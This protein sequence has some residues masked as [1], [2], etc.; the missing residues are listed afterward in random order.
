MK[1]ININI[2]QVV[3]IGG[4]FAI[5]LVIL[6]LVVQY[7]VKWEDRD[8]DSYLFFYNCNNN[9]CTTNNKID[10]YY[11]YIKCNGTECPYI[12]EIKDNLVILST[13]DKEYVYDYENDNI[14]N[15]TYK[16]YSF[17]DDNYIVMDNSGNYGIINGV[18]EV[19]VE[20]QYSQITA[21]KDNYIVYK[22][23]DKAG[24]IN[25]EKQ[26]DIKPTYEDIVLINDSVYGYVEDNKYY[27]ASYD[28][29]LPINNTS[30]DYLYTI[31]NNN[32]LVI[33]D[34]KLDIIDS[35][36]NSALI[37][38]LDTYYKYEV[39]KERSSL[40]LN[41]KGNILTF[42]IIQDEDKINNYIYDIKNKKIYD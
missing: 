11:S 7:K 37:L 12:K 39:E 42:S 21:Y 2:W 41:K 32:I 24:I 31:D 6:H 5:L 17:T 23:D 33:K 3:W 38:K 40:K 10:G 25:E 4:I 14:I 19:V 18:G 27:I 8:L 26:I 28:T 16:T 34:N 1:K 29:E 20:P 15:D 22:S 30:Y 35:N 13:N 9:L 36:L